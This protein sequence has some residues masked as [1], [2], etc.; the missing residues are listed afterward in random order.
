MS[1]L[2]QPLDQS[3]SPRSFSSLFRK[4]HAH[5][6]RQVAVKDGSTCFF[7][8]FGS[9]FS[10][11]DH[12]FSALRIMTSAPAPPATTSTG[13]GLFGGKSKLMAV[14][15][16]E[17]RLSLLWITAINEGFRICFQGHGHGFSPRWHR[18][19]ERQNTKTEFSHR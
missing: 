3:D 18:R 2:A 19:A 16:D 17:V 14:I 13:H 1:P 10:D 4:Q 7:L 11:S 8:S 15:G 5:F 6:R 12:F 9:S